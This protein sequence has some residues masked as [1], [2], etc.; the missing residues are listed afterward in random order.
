MSSATDVFARFVDLVAELLDDHHTRHD[1]VAR[2]AHMSRFHFDRL[3]TAASGETPARFRRRVLLERSAYR[4]LEPEITV[5]DVAVEAGYSSHE[6]FIRAFARAYGVPPTRWRSRPARLALDTPNGVHFHPPAGLTLP[7]RRKVGPMELLYTIVEHN[8]WLT[9]QL[10]DRAAGLSDD[11]L[12]A[13]IEVSVETLDDDPTL[14]RELRYLVFEPEVWLAAVEGR[15]PVE[16]GSGI[17]EL[18]AQNAVSGPAYVA[19]VRQLGDAGRLDEAFVD[20][21]CEPP[22]VFTYGGMVAHTITF[23]AAHRAMVIGALHTAGITDLG[24]GD[25]MSF[26]AQPQ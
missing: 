11:V 24:A 3:I 14:R 16:F 22:E 18:R 21:V 9:E 1:D 8:H 7:A 2:R 19:I 20:A 15:Q 6:A 4:L 23:A 26:V 12:D 13:P 17:A 5:L 25:P 10:L